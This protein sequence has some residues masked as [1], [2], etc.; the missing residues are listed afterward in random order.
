MMKHCFYEYFIS[1]V[2]SNPL[3]KVARACKTY[4]AWM[5]GSVKKELYCWIRFLF[6]FFYLPVLFACSI[7]TLKIV[8]HTTKKD[9]PL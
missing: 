1:R 6:C 4:F 9:F 8:L 7:D 2:F 3:N 5:K